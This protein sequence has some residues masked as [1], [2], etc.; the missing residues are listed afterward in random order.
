MNHR[1]PGV[2]YFPLGDQTVKPVFDF[3]HNAFLQL[4][5]EGDYLSQ[6]NE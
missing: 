2:C 6:T 4:M 1:A 3:V 5:K